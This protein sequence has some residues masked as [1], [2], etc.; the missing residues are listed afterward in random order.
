MTHT[1]CEEAVSL[2]GRRSERETQQT[3]SNS[4]LMKLGEGGGEGAWG[5]T[6]IVQSQPI[7]EN[8]A[9]GWGD[10]GGG[11][12]RVGGGGGRGR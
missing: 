8:G 1:L 6:T 4:F 11:E 12:V 7:K 9:G 3:V 5:G 2:T 10:E